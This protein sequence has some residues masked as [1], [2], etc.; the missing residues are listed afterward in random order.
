MLAESDKD[1]IKAMKLYFEDI[2]EGEEYT[3]GGRTITEAD[4]VNF[5]GISGDFNPLHMDEEYAKGTI[6]GRRVAHGLLT[7]AVAIG[8]AQQ[9][10]FDIV[11]FR[12]VDKLRF[13]HPVFIGDTIKVTQKVV[14][15][16]L[17]E[18]LGGGLVTLESTVTNQHGKKVLRFQLKVLVRSKTAQFDREI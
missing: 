12:G 3:S 16:R 17:Q 13:S 9:A 6:F 10:G 14:S 11:A 15:K 7:L 1:I 4:V 18:K 8:L 5:A 2:E